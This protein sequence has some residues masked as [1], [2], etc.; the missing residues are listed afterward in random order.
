MDGPDCVTHR[1]G[2][3]TLRAVDGF[4]DT[5]ATLEPCVLTSADGPWG[6]CL[7]SIGGEPVDFSGTRQ[8][9]NNWQGIQAT[10][11]GRVGPGWVPLTR[12]WAPSANFVGT[13]QLIHY[14]GA[15]VNQF[16]LRIALYR[17]GLPDT[18]WPLEVPNLWVEM[19]C[20][21]GGGSKSQGTGASYAISTQV[22]AND[23]G[24]GEDL[25]SVAATPERRRLLVEL[26]APLPVGTNSCGICFRANQMIPSEWVPIQFGR[27]Y[28]FETT[29]P[30]WL[31]T[32]PPGNTAVRFAV[33]EEIG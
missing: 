9:Q 23:N 5:E 14:T 32:D 1:L 30:V 20:G 24:A 33:L 22:R 11:Y 21:G 28:A 10:L 17:S 27:Q 18:S 13:R 31:A 7:V 4:Q 16:Q 2:P 8:Q 6:S 25:P 29:A 3:V 12:A 15:T 19:V 26:V